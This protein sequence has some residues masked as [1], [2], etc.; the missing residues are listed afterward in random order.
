[1]FMVTVF[2]GGTVLDQLQG[3]LI[4][5]CQPVVGGP[6][7]SPN[8][9]AAMAAAAEAGGAAGLRVEG[10]ANVQA[11]RARSS[12]PIIGLIKRDLDDSPVRITPWLID[13]D[14]LVE[15]GANIIAVDATQRLRP[16]SVEKLIEHIHRS[17]VVAM[18]DCATAADGRVARAAGA[19]I[20]GSTL[21]GYTH[22]EPPSEPD[23]N[24]ISALRALDSF[25]VAEGRYQQPQQASKALKL[26]ADAV[27]VGSAITRPE[28]ITQWFVQAMAESTGTVVQV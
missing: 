6:L 20:L 23:Y 11:V 25:V 2:E 28:H 19:D 12:L 1:M 13:I 4:V 7:D 17:R 5:S 27:V 15:A 9:V 16:V 22:G 24:L 18:A 14:E 10:V 8:M 26:G 3:Q 21:S